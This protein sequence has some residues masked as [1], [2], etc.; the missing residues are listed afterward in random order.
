MYKR[1]AFITTGG[2][3][4][5]PIRQL[6]EVN[7]TVQKGLAAAEDIFDLFDEKRENDDGTEIL[8]IVRGEVEFRDVSFRYASDLP[9]VL[10]ALSFHISPGE[11][12]ALVGKS[13]SGKSTL[14]SLIPR[15]YSPTKGS[16]LIDGKPIDSLS[17]ANLRQHIAI[18]TQDITLFNDTI[19]RNIAYGN[20]N[21]FNRD[22]VI[23]AA[24]KAYIWDFIASL[25]Q[26]LDLSLIHI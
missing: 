3:L 13:G 12:I 7:A 17:L 11:T 8:E 5:K 25:D 9:N 26:G 20:L 4:A 14:A 10:E 15:F 24:K 6:A 2:L 23:E 19:T 18:V 21:H 16:I 1:Q 22:E